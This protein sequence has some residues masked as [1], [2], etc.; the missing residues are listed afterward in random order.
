MSLVT[1]LVEVNKN[2]DGTSKSKKRPKARS[3]T[4]VNEDTLSGYLQAPVEESSSI[5]SVLNPGIISFYESQNQVADLRLQNLDVPGISKCQIKL[6][7]VSILIDS[8]DFALL[9]CV[10]CFI[11]E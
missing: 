1:F 8:K 9:D 10:E 11:R 6:L 2:R 5:A 3:S 7:S 4:I